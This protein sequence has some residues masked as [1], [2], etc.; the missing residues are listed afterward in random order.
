MK[1]RTRLPEPVRNA[2]MRARARILSLLGEQLIGNDRLAIFELVKNAYDADASHVLVELDG[3][4]DGSP[5]IVVQDDGE[6]MSLE[7]ITGVWLEPG[8]DHRQVQRE[9]LERSPKFRRLPLG[10]KGVGRFAVHKLGNRI[11]L[12]TRRRGEPEYRIDIDWDR[13]LKRKYLAQARI[14]VFKHQKPKFFEGAKHGTRIEIGSLKRDK[15]TRGDVRNVLRLLTSINSPFED[16][17]A[18]RTELKVAGHEDWL[19]GLPS[20]AELI[21]GA[22]WRFEFSFDGH[23]FSWSYRFRAPAGIKVSGRELSSASDSLLLPT[24]PGTRNRVVADAEMLKGI[25]PIS[26]KLVAYDKDPKI[27][28]LIPQISLLTDFLDASS[29]VRVYRDGIRVFNYG[30]PEDDWLGLDLRRVNRPTERLSRNIVIG[31][32]DLDLSKSPALREK[33]NREGFDENDGYRRFHELVLAVI[34]KFE[35]ERDLDKDRLKK[36][37]EGAHDAIIIPVEKPL[38]DLRRAIA[39]AGLEKELLPYVDKVESDYTQ[40]RELMLRSGMAGV[41]LALVFHE[42]ERGVRSLYEAI[43]RKQDFASIEIQASSLMRM[44][45]DIAGLLK[46]KGSGRIAVRETVQT[47]AR[48]ASKRFERHQIKATFSLGDDSEAL[49]LKGS[50]DLLLGTLSNLIDNS[51]YWLRVRWPEVADGEAPTRRLHIAIT[52]ELGGRS[53]VV[54]DNGTGFQDDPDVLIRPFFTRRPDG[55][56]L[57]L[58]YASVA[59]QLNGGRLEFPDK[60]DLGLPTEL[61]GALIALVFPDGRVVK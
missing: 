27:R 9:S 31:A 32:I 45:E 1:K 28:R 41:N 38:A 16:K 52:D 57:G 50:E 10:E 12:I 11:T 44:F 46:Q 13:L 53:L 54:A 43:R 59:T 5:S 2:P 6:G 33:T 4:D 8:S 19:A 17:A 24:K 20:A 39:E 51:I 18:F 15:W 61:D 55:M 42:A 47:A 22:P 23:H 21:E 60:T 35:T 34:S 30:E 7:T 49:V 36:A 29:G 14:P 40:V 58:Y 25:G 3:L 48:L 37:V 56:G 26:G